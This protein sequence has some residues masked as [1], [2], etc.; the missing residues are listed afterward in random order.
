MYICGNWYCYTSEM[1]VSRPCITS[2]IYHILPPII[3]QLCS[4]GLTMVLYQGLFTGCVVGLNGIQISSL[5][6]D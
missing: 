1:T 5:I 2:T 6:R 3:V 4:V